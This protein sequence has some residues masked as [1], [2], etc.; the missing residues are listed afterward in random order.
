MAASVLAAVPT[1]AAFLVLRR[2]LIEGLT[3]GSVKG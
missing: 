3:V 1:I 2:Q